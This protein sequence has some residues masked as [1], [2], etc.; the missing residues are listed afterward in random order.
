MR[1]F[2]RI[3]IMFVAITTLLTISLLPSCT[4]TDREAEQPP[5]TEPQNWY[6]DLVFE[7]GSFSFELARAMGYSYSGGADVGE[8]LSTARRIKDGDDQSWYDEWLATANR[9]YDFAQMMEEEGSVVSRR[10]AYF[11]ASNY[12][13]AA[14]FYMHS[15]ANRPKSLESW[16][17]SRESFLKAISS[18]PYIEPISIPYENTTLPGYFVK[19]ESSGQTPPLLIVHTGFD[20]TGEELYFEVALA[21]V[22]RGYNCLIFEGPGQGEVIRVQNIPF[23]HDWEKAVTPVVDYAVARADVDEDK[24]ALMGISLGGYLAP[25]AAAFEP[26]IRACIANGGVFNASGNIY[27]SFPPELIDLLETNKEKFNSEIEEAMKQDTTIRWFFNN[28]IWTFGA[29]SPAEVML[30]LRHYTLKDVVKNIK[31]N[32]LVLD[33]EADMFYKGQAKQLYDELD[34]PKDY[35]MFTKS[36]AAQA[37]CQMGAIAISNEVIFNWLDKIFA[38]SGDEGEYGPPFIES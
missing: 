13:R 29:E 6:D 35:I 22:K 12:Y 32:M 37:H 33:S 1:T 15:E 25:R 8:C 21:A 2:T 24:I 36:E 3:M 34:C 9:L 20:G 28:G 30:K 23:R 4:K 19:T 11:R 38:G 5:Q 7:D 26:R 31:C 27:K 10:E 17:K 14:G 18:L 16:S